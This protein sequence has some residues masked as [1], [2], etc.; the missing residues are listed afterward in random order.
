MGCKRAPSPKI[1][2]AGDFRDELGLQ[3]TIMMFDPQVWQPRDSS[4]APRF[5]ADNE[6]LYTELCAKYKTLTPK[7]K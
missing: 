4:A 2:N 3:R 7:S 6:L 1:V 5:E